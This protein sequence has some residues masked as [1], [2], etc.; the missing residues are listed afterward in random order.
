MQERV[1]STNISQ[2][3]IPP[4][5]PVLCGG[6]FECL[7]AAIFDCGHVTAIYRAVDV[8]KDRHFQ[9]QVDLSARPRDL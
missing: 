1:I 6:P 5:P 3:D 7:F 8:V 4:G 9:P 2:G